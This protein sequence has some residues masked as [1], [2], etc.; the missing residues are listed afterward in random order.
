MSVFA[1]FMKCCDKESDI[2]GAFAEKP[3]TV[4][5][6]GALLVRR[7]LVLMNFNMRIARLRLRASLI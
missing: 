2:V 6:H 1:A 5:T 3:V 4:H 7:H